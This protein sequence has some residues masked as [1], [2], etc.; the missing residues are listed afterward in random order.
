MCGIS[1][2]LRGPATVCQPIQRAGRIGRVA[3]EKNI[4]LELRHDRSLI[5]T[6]LARLSRGSFPAM[7][8]SR[9]V[10]VAILLHLGPYKRRVPGSKVRIL[11]SIEARGFDVAIIG[12][13]MAGA[14]YARLISD[15]APGARVLVIEAGPQL[16][17]TAG[18]HIRNFTSSTEREQAALRA[19][20]PD[21]HAHSA[22]SVYTPPESALG[23]EGRLERPGLFLLEPYTGN[24]SSGMPSAAMTSCVGGMGVLWR[25]SCPRPYGS[26]ITSLIPRSTFNALIRQAYELLGV[27]PDPERKDSIINT[28]CHSL[29]DV[30][31]ANVAPGLRAR[32]LPLA[33]S[34]EGNQKYWFGTEKILGAIADGMADNV[35]ILPDTVCRSVLVDQGRAVGVD[36]VGVDGRRVGIFRTRFV[37]IAADPFRTPQLLYASGVRPIVLGRYL[38]EHI[39]VTSRVEL[40]GA[41]KEKMGK[42]SRNIAQGV[43]G[44]WLPF[45]EE[46]RPYHGQIL[47]EI[48][49]SDPSD[50]DGIPRFVGISLYGRKDVDDADRVGFS[51]TQTDFFGMPK[52]SIRYRLT[53]N[54]AYT[55]EYMKR[56]IDRIAGALGSSQG[57]HVHP[58][59]ASLHYQGTTRMGHSAT[60]AVCDSFGRVH[61]YRN[62][63]IGGAGLIDTAT[64]CN[65]AL[66]VVALA[67]RGAEKVASEIA[68]V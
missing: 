61:G 10:S 57:A 54:D 22:T 29:A 25:G 30:V 60:T 7:M 20:G 49:T 16:S 15:L 28:I 5:S 3:A 43:G 46:A 45:A 11:H 1:L 36:L 59:G 34:I 38:N 52:M 35:S 18:M 65:P 55:T 63:Y 8:E 41:L 23:A 32:Q 33:V 14:T 24:T 27:Q 62:L 9:W 12:S 19:Q 2:R 56:A 26:E 68:T 13:G 17:S 44:C 42:N 39:Q 67:I 51:S 21:R 47:Y 64:A 31:D 66:T 48:D 6:F 58:P 40:S 50:Q 53:E 4:S 37:V